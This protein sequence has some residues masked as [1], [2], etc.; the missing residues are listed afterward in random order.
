MIRTSL[1]QS[2]L[3]LIILAL[4]QSTAAAQTAARPDRGVMP[5]GSYSVADIEN[6]NLT[7]GN[8][9]LSIPLASLP[10][11]AGGKLSWTISAVY[12]SKLW[13]MRVEERQNSHLDPVYAVSLPQM[14]EQ[15]GWRIGGAYNIVTVPVTNDYD[16]IA[17]PEDPEYLILQQPW[18]K[19]LLQMPDGAVHELRPIDFSPYPGSHGFL[20]GYFADNPNSIG[21]AMR[22]YS[23]DGSY[24][25]AKLYP[26]TSSTSWEVYLPDGTKIIQ[27]SSGIQRIIDRNGNSIKIFSDGVGGVT[28]THYQ[29]EQTLREIKYSFNAAGNNGQGLG[30]VQYQTVGGGWASID[31]NFGTTEVH[32]KVYNIQTANFC[33]YQEPIHSETFGVVRE[34]VFPQ[35]EPNLPRQKY[36]FTYNSDVSDSATVTWQYWCDQFS[37]TTLT[38]T[39]SHG[40]GSLSRM[41]TPQ[42]A[43]VDYTYTLNGNHS[44]D[45]L[46][47]AEESLNQKSVSHDGMV[48]TWAYNVT[49]NGGSVT[50]PDGSVTTETFFTHSSGHSS[51]QGGATGLGGLVYRTNQSGKVLTERHW[52]R[53]KFNGAQENAPNS[54]L[55]FNPVVDAEYTSLLGGNPAQPVKMSA[56]KFQ[57]DYNGNVIQVTEYDWFDPA[58]VTRDSGGIPVDVPAGATVLRVVSHSYYNPS[59]TSSSSNVYAKRALATATPLILNALQQTTVGPSITQLS[60]D[61]QAYG[62]APTVGNLTTAKAWDNLNNKWITSSHSYG[63]YGNRVTSSDPRGKVTQYFFDDATHALPNRVVVDPQNGTGSQTTTTAYDFWTGLVTSQTDANNQAST[64]NYTNQLLGTVD[65]FG[66]PGITLAP[67]VTINGSPHRRRATTFYEDAARRVRV[68]SDLNAENDRLLKVRTTGDQLGRTVLTEQSEDGNTYTISST[69]VYVQMGKITLTSSPRRSTASSSDGWTRTTKDSM[70]RIVEVATFGGV[71]QPPNTGTTST[72]TGSV[73][74]AYDAN[75]TTV[76]DQIGK[77]RRS[78]VD[79]LGRLK[80]VDEPDASNNLGSQASPVQPT[81]YTYDVFGNLLTVVQGAQTRTFVYDS[82]SR[83]RSATN[84]ESGTITYHYDDNGNL[85]QKTDARGVISVYAYDALN[86]NTTID[87]SDTSS[88]N[89]DITRV[90]DTATNG[91]GQLRESYIGGSETAGATVEHTKIVSYDAFGRPLD[92]R[93][94]FKSNSVWGSEYRVQR[95]YNLAG[96]VASQTYPSG[97]TVTY[98]NDNAGR[99]SSFTGTL[100]DGVN[101]NY[102]TEIVYSSL[103]GMAKEKFGTDTPLYNKSFYNSRGQLSEIRV[104]TTYTGV[105]DGGWQRGAIINHY[106]AQCWGACNGTDNN[107]NVKSQ[108]HWIPNASGGVQAIF[109]Q[110]YSYDNLNRL[111]RANEGSNWQQEFVYDRWGNRTIHQTNTWGTGINKKD[112]TVNTANNRLGVPGGQSGVMTYDAAGNLTNDTYTGAGSRVY[113]AGNRMTKA[114]GGNNQWQEYTYN[115]DG[116]R[117]RRKIDG[118]ETWQIY[119]FAGELLAEYTA[120]GAPA[121]PKKEYGY[122]NGQLLVTA[123]V[124]LTSGVGLQAQYFDNINFTDLKVTRTDATVNFDWAGGTPDPVIGVDT[125]TTRWQGKVEPQYSQTYTFYTLTDDGVR[126]WIN[127]QLVIDKWLDQGPT[128]WSGSIALTAGQRY[129]VVMEFYENGGGATAKLSWSSA[130]QPK[131]IIPQSRL[132]PPGSSSQ[133]AFEWLVTD[134]LG[135][136]RIILDKTGSLATTRRHDYLPFG[137][138]LFAGM[139][140]R[141]TALGYTSDTIRQKFTSKE[142]DGETGLDY[143][144]HR[145]YSSM[146]G[147]FTSADVPF[148]DQWESNPQSWNLYTYVGNQPLSFTDPLGLWR[149]VDC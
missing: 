33:N 80:R 75:F 132:Y 9:H 44:I 56:K 121:S 94:R 68:E 115:A 66:R 45:P 67:A 11:I 58:L 34:I 106:S 108:D 43:V 146:S 145:Y 28:T 120:N 35:T 98:G 140:G 148:A 22:Y 31:I 16:Y 136:P 4:F 84:P 17:Q 114:W 65:P 18:H 147:R 142:R 70:G 64:I 26:Y 102:S 72:W 61:N 135:T 23:Y 29:D 12:N 8:L 53:M 32:G 137:E 2:A 99:L 104:G 14:S 27:L 116:Q 46:M 138:E 131:Q 76:T 141:T 111:L 127:G 110:S 85:T 124:P 21:S 40:W 134:Q 38:T 52:T 130:S 90:Y 47:A 37:F 79:G 101:R 77:V 88:I 128:E 19:I 59:T 93:Q 25:W 123:T 125:F 73:T 112:F 50:A 41:I 83:F 113:D 119:G 7:N 55:V 49:Y 95:L 109:T 13:D 149:R 126:L 1:R 48:D 5:Y 15:G 118:V 100:G 54:V 105:T 30:Q 139:G 42:G 81:T 103:G 89:P 36:S 133:V 144:I 91:K 87:Y 60:Y 92:Q 24:I 62:V 143:F 51:S 20:I 39:P 86:R 96:G 3:L 63:L 97:R 78:M 117:T 82:L 71:A 107:G 10:P 122:R 57:H 129:D 6:I 69:S 74:T